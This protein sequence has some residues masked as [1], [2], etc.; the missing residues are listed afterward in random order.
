MAVIFSL[1]TCSFRAGKKDGWEVGSGTRVWMWI[2][3]S[4]DEEQ[5]WRRLKA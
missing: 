2:W 1:T 4:G 3:V 5:I